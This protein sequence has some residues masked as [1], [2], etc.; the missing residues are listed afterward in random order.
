MKLKQQ[1]YAQV[2][3]DSN[4][5]DAR[6]VARFLNSEFGKEIRESHKT[7]SIIYKLNKKS[8]MKL[9]IFIPNLATQ[10]EM[11]SIEAQIT[12]KQNV[13]LGLQNELMDNRRELWSN[14]KSAAKVI[15]K[16]QV[17]SSRFSGSLKQH[18]DES[19]EHWIDT[20]PFPLA[21]ILRAWQA[22]PSD[23]FKSKY[24]HLLHFFEANAEFLS[25]I[26]LSAFSSQESIF[27]LHREKLSQILASQKLS[28]KRATFGTWKIT[29]EYLG[30]QTRAL[31]DGDEESRNLCTSMFVETKLAELLGRKEL[32]G[33]INS[34]N[35]MRIDW[36]AHSGVVGKADSKLRNEQLIE[37]LQT[38]RNVT[39]DTWAEV[40][41]L[42]ALHCRPRHGVFENEVAILMGS[43]S[44]FLKETRSMS[45][46]MDV[47]L[48]YLAKENTGRALQ[49]LPLVQVGPSPESAKNACYFFNRL[50]NDGMRFV[51][52]HFVDRPELKGTFEASGALKSLMEI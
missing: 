15:G 34:T 24:E 46:W 26:L 23:D 47:E 44:E 5:S 38:L 36:L 7:G 19:L 51:S 43:N 48:L 32:P 4:R 6:F 22:T 12:E 1:N 13:L 50:E 10:K 2:V 17:L 9:E 52:Y 28:Y 40:Q 3:I 14:P 41:L 21:S 35:K 25:A 33:I 39:G 18:A 16:L 29:V 45:M 20:L 37:Q 27:D 49:L 8:I 42:Q 11:I 31:L 30:K